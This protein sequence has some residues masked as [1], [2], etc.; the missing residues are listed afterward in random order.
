[1]P[2]LVICKFKNDMI[3]TTDKNVETS[4]FEIGQLASEIFKFK[5]V[6]DDGR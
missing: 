5:C 2:V 3:K 1:M 6:D 4:F